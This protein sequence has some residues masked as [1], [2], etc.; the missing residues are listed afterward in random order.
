MGLSFELK[1]TKNIQGRVEYASDEECIQLPNPHEAREL[2]VLGGVMEGD[3][4]CQAQVSGSGGRVGATFYSKPCKM[5]G[6]D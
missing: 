3:E 4:H 2:H 1:T 5:Y 6:K